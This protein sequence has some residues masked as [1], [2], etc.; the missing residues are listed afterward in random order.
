MLRYFTLRFSARTDDPLSR[1]PFV[2]HVIRAMTSA[3]PRDFSLT[4]ESGSRLYY[5]H[6]KRSKQATGAGKLA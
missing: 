3:V 5:E 2:P 4:S 6:T 1:G